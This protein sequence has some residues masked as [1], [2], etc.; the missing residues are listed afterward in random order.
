MG[1]ELESF[2]KTES[3]GNVV[4]NCLTNNTQAFWNSTTTRFCE[5]NS[6][7]SKI[8]NLSNSPRNSRHMEVR[9]RI[10]TIRTICKL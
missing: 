5:S 6:K 1:C 9:Y 8:A 3:I 4:I 2:S 7:L 10:K